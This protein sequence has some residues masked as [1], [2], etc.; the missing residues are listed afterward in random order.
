MPRRQ[1]LRCHKGSERSNRIEEEMPDRVRIG[2][3]G[4]GLIA[5]LMHLHYLGELSDRFE[6]AA[7]C[8]I[9][10]GLA[11]GCAERFGAR[12]PERLAAE[13]PA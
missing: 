9:S 13:V 1:A 8:D 3:V 5:Q 2:L 4:G 10:P 6:L 12:R 11:A 7:V